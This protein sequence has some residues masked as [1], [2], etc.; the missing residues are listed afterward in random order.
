MRKQKRACLKICALLMSLMLLCVFMPIEA[1][2]ESEENIDITSWKITTGGSVKVDL[3]IEKES[4]TGEYYLNIP[5]TTV[6]VFSYLFAKFRWNLEF[7]Q[8]V[9]Y[10]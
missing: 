1:F 10:C 6:S 4:D 5:D 7:S 8:I 2:G 3:Q 9:S